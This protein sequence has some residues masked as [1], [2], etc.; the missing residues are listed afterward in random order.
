MVYRETQAAVLELVG[1]FGQICYS[2][3]HINNYLVSL[4]I[5]CQNLHNFHN[6]SSSKDDGHDKSQNDGETDEWEKD[7]E[8]GSERGGGGDIALKQFTRLFYRD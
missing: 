7:R 4:T 6:S 8:T 2:I 1:N 3:Q 5:G